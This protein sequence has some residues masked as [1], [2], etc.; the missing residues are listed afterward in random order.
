MAT[1]FMVTLTRSKALLAGWL[2]RLLEARKRRIE[3][4]REFYHSLNT[5]CRTNN[6]SPICEDD[7]KVAAYDKGDHSISMINSIN[8]KGHVP[9][10]KASLPR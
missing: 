8:S 3:R 10:T 4:E 1:P 5:Y 2:R 9:W 6:L 7:W